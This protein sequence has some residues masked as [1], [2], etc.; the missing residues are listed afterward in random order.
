MHVVN[1]SIAEKWL[2]QYGDKYAFFMSMN[3]I[4]LIAEQKIER[5]EKYEDI[6]K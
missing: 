4:V 5:L 2:E 6:E 1:Y 3:V